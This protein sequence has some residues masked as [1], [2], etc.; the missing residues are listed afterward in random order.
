MSEEACY[1]DDI[2]DYRWEGFPLEQKIAWMRNAQGSAAVRPGVEALRGLSARYAESHRTVQAGLA[3]LGISWQGQSAEAAGQAVTRLA[4][5]VGGAGQTVSGGGGSMGTYGASFDAMRPRINPPA[6][7]PAV[8]PVGPRYQPADGVGVLAG[9]QWAIRQQADA[10][11]AAD[12]Q[13]NA[14]LRAHQQATRAALSSFPLV[15]PPPDVV[16]GVGSSTPADAAGGRTVPAPGGA[17]LGPRSGGAGAPQAGKAAGG[18]VPTGGTSGPGSATGGA[19]GGP[20]G[21]QD[22]GQQDAGQQGAG[23][24]GGTTSA[25]AGAPAPAIDGGWT[26]LSPA[27]PGGGSGGLVT[28]PNGGLVPASIPPQYRS[29]SGVGGPTGLDRF[30]PGSG[31]PAGQGGPGRYEGPLPPRTGAPG[32]RF[33]GNHG[34]D[35]GVPQNTAGRSGGPTGAAPM[36]MG[37]GA[38]GGEER[39]HRNQ[40]FIPSDE[41]FRVEFF[42]VTPPVLGVRPEEAW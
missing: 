4:D 41:P 14:A 23:P 36:G 24:S 9:L 1:A 29:G 2:G 31:G 25:G 5:W 10:T 15:E 22:A 40:T 8:P 7:I 11:A 20:A 17:A 21:Q 35:F 6:P 18:G 19:S 32:P 28:G 39:N 34:G 16:A 37:G 38:R 13:A 30:G 26:P 33:G 3:R 27:A 42:D 12:A